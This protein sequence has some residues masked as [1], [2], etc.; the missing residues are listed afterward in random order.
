MKTFLYYAAAGFTLG[1]ALTCLCFY[2]ATL[3]PTFLLEVSSDGVGSHLIATFLPAGALTGFLAC[4]LV[5]MG[6]YTV[7]RFSER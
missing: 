1:L 7:A 6:S 3:N 5:S 4:S 2:F